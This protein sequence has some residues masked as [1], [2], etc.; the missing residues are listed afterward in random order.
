LKPR[1]SRAGIG[2][3]G[4]VVV[5]ALTIV[6]AF[7]AYYWINGNISAFKKQV[8]KIDITTKYRQL[9]ISNCPGNCSGVILVVKNEGS[10]HVEITDVYVNGKPWPKDRVWWSGY[11]QC[12]ASNLETHALSES[13]VTLCPS[14]WSYISICD[15][16]RVFQPGRDYEI[17]LVTGR[18]NVFITIMQSDK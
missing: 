3:I 4:L 2:A 15:P 14:F 6:L 11:P 5:I 1:L 16:G 12:D 7:V 18:G 10:S 13:A 9:S 8:E 17:K